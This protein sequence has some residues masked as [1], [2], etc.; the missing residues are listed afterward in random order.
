LTLQLG[1]VK[2]EFSLIY[3]YSLRMCFANVESRRIAF[4]L[5]SQEK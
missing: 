5:T 2:W 4:E 3:S 1:L